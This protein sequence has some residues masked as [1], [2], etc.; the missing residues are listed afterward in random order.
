MILFDHF[1]LSR[2]HQNYYV[3][4]YCAKGGGVNLNGIPLMSSGLCYLRD[5]HSKLIEK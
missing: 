1:K 3:N 2:K 4:Y 5:E